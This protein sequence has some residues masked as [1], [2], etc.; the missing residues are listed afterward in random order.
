MS[1]IYKITLSCAIA[2]ALMAGAAVAADEA[3]EAESWD[4]SLAVGANLNQGNT[5]TMGINAA[6]TTERDYEKMAYRFG[7]EAN[8]GENTTMAEDG[9][10]NTDKTT[11]NAKAYAN[12]KRKLGTPYLYSDNSVLHDEIGG[13]DYRVVI[14]AGGGAYVLDNDED[15]LGLEAGLAYIVE[16]FES[17]DDDDSLALRLAARHDHTFSETAK[18]WASVEYLPSMDAFGDYLLNAEIGTETVLNSTLSL[19][20]VAQDRYDSEPPAGLEDNDLSVIAAL[21]YKP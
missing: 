19:R 17:G 14:G 2:M 4:T 8:Y 21:V 16:K 12:I 1:G 20:V 18:C 15:K 13:I 9:S 3:A 10:E 5:E 11:Q 6:L 7:I